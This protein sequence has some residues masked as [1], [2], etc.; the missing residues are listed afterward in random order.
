MKRKK[1]FSVRAFISLLL[2][3]SFL[4]LAVSGIVIYFAPSCSVAE[5]MGWTVAGISK[6]QWSSVHMTGALSFLA[7]AII[8]IFIYN[9]KPILNYFRNKRTVASGSKSR[10]F[11]PEAITSIIVAVVVLGGAGAL[12]FP[13]SLLSEG[14]DA[15]KDY[16]RDVSEFEGRGEGRGQN[17][18]LVSPDT[19]SQQAIT[20]DFEEPIEAEHENDY[21]RP[22]KGL[23]GEGRG[24]GGRDDEERG[25]GR[26]LGGRDDDERGEGR[27]LGRRQ[28]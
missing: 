21:E 23:E 16:Y 10:S 5:E 8:H 26:G 4:G 24:L 7:F 2:G 19:L 25:E 22:R 1:S 27:G 13:F 14:N 11:R 18:T 3:F 28:N 6:T 20:F 17:A 12:I 9:W 15:I